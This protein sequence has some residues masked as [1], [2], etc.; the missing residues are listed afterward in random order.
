[1]GRAMKIAI[2]S[3]IHGNI[4]ALEEIMKLPE[5]K[6]CDLRINA[7]DMVGYYFEPRRV[8]HMVQE[9]NFRTVKGNHELMLQKVRSEDDFLAAISLSYGVGHAIAMEQLNEID[10]DYLN[11]LPLELVLKTPEGN[12]F[13]CHGS[14][15][16]VDDYIYP[17]TLL[18]SIQF[19]LDKDIR[20]LLCGNTHWQMVRKEGDLLIINPGSVGQARD[21]SGLA[22]WA[23]LDTVSG[24]VVF[25]QTKYD[26]TAL[27]SKTKN[28]N[29]ELPKL[30]EVLGG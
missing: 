14:P 17:D 28:L 27:I 2:L 16:S 4:D 24:E 20:W 11:S 7:G 30:W 1:M 9:G 5:F 19:Q 12:L 23:T 26:V 18:S 10:L 8:L 3:D 25:Y 15:Q 21:R 6:S 22:H 29:P 13:V